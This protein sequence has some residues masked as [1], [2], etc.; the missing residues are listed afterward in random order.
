MKPSTTRQTLCVAQREYL[1]TVRTKGFLIGLFV[2]PLLMF[3]AILAIPLFQGYRDTADRH[4]AI[5]D[6]TSRLHPAIIN[7]AA[8]RN[9]NHI[10]HPASGKKQAPAYLIENLPPDLTNPSPSRIAYA[11]KISTR[12][13]KSDPMSSTPAQ[14]PKPP[15]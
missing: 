3:G 2:A 4:I 13:S 14:T 12:S 15:A 9:Q 8:D 7:A 6:H 11:Q 10:H 1:A 5:L